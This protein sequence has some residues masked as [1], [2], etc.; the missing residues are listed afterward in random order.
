MKICLVM[1]GNNVHGRILAHA[2]REFSP[3]VLNEAGTKRA[4][5]LAQWLAPGYGPSCPEAISIDDYRG[6]KAR[7]YLRDCDYAVNGGIGILDSEM[8]SLPRK[9]W[10]N[11]HPGLLP[12]YRGAEPVLWALKNGDPQG[13]TVHLLDEGIDTGP[14]LLKR[15]MPPQQ[16]RSVKE[17]RLKVMEFGAMMTKEF[18]GDPINYKPEPQP[19]Y[20]GRTYQRFCAGDSE[21]AEVLLKAPLETYSAGWW[22]RVEGGS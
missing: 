3:V 4:G 6:E 20:A 5:Q 22:Q 14:I 7:D 10:V 16:V 12:E 18:F 17:L 8:L 15:E 19:R 2:V 1:A 13:A 21:A 9:G 11:A